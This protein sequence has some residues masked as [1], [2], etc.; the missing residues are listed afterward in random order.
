MKFKL[1]LTINKPREEM[2]R[3]GL[4]KQNMKTQDDHHKVSWA[5]VE[6][7]LRQTHTKRYGSFQGTGGKE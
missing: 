3:Y 5:F 2:K 6:K 4:L 7:G 1:E